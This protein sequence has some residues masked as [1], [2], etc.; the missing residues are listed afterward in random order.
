MTSDPK[1]QVAQ[2]EEVEST[3]PSRIIDVGHGNMPEF[4]NDDIHQAALADN[5]AKAE[6]LNWTTY[7]AIGVCWPFRLLRTLILWLNVWL[8]MFPKTSF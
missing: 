1:T 3:T 7:L 5:P 8:M 4:D 2:A 6:K